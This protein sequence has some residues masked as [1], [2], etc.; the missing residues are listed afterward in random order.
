MSAWR[1]EASRRLPELQPIIAARHVDGPMMLWIDLQ[2]EFAR[3]CERDPPPLDL[4]R[5]IWQYA[6]WCLRHEDGD[7]RTGAALGFCEH[8]I[9]TPAGRA[10]LPE[11]ITRTEY[12]G[13]KELLLYHNTVE[14]Y[15]A[16]LRAF[17]PPRR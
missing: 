12:Q 9:D 6:A 15:E 8:L 11:L 2:S 16:G 10:L 7:V 3:A 14:Q 4:L 1:R 13:C 17:D 5:R